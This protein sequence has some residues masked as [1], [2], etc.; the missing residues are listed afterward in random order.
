[1]NC[2]CFPHVERRRAP[3]KTKQAGRF[4]GVG[5]TWGSTMKTISLIAI[6]AALVGPAYAQEDPLSRAT[7]AELVE[8]LKPRD[9]GPRLRGLSISQRITEPARVDLAIE[10]AFGSADLTDEARSLLSE[11]ADAM[12]S[13]ALEG[14][15]F[16]VGGHT[17]A[18]GSEPYNLALS[19]ERARAVRQY[20]ASERGIEAARL[21]THG[22]GMS[23]LLFPD[24]PEDGRNRRVE[25]LAVE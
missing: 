25:I 3:N 2:T 4:R 14:L 5:Q 15:R 1:M 9:D 18:V 21:E 10:F 16:R 17:D 24:L 7:A 8:R 6:L 12:R 23:R 19:K 13:E 20:L 22:Y 11:L